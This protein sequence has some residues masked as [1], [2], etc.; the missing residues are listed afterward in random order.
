MG[1]LDSTGCNDDKV[2]RALSRQ[3]MAVPKPKLIPD[4]LD[5]S[6][7]GDMQVF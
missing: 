7:L 1:W 5:P 6:C 3:L 4:N 2:N